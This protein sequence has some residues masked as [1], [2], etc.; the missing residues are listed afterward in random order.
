MNF[1]YRGEGEY[2]KPLFHGITSMIPTIHQESQWSLWE[3][4]AQVIFYLCI[5]MNIILINLYSTLCISIFFCLTDN[6]PDSKYYGYLLYLFLL[7]TGNPQGP[8]KEELKKFDCNW[9]TKERICLQTR[10]GE[11][12][13]C[14]ICS[15]LYWNWICSA[16]E[17]RYR[18]E[19]TSASFGFHHFRQFWY[20][21][22]Q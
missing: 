5:K 12:I 21:L 22:L 18:R 9:N 3:I 13:F 6:C 10:K 15:H 1:K 2:L 16:H 20:Y 14:I 19:K 8:F 4:L 11:S 17:G 7:S